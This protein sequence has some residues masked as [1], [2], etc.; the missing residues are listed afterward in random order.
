MGNKGNQNKTR[1]I[2][3][4]WIEIF[5]NM[6]VVK[7]VESTGKC[8]ISADEIKKVYEP[9]LMTKFDYKDSLPSIFVENS[10]TILP[11]TRGSYV[12]GKY[13]AYEDFETVKTNVKKIDFPEWIE[14][15]DYKN[16]YSEASVINCAYASKIFSDILG[17]TEMYP[18]LN[19]RMGSGDF[20][21]YINDV[22]NKSCKVSVSKAQCEID[23]AFESRNNILLLEAKNN[24]FEDFI[25]RQLYYPYRV[26]QNRVSKKVIP[27]FLTYSNNI[28]S[29]Y[30]YEFSDINHY[31]SLKL[32]EVKRYMIDDFNITVE[33]VKD[34]LYNIKIVDE[35]MDIPFPQA[36]TFENIISLINKMYDDPDFNMKDQVT[37]E[38]GF[39]KRQADY[40]TNA[41][42]YLGLVDRQRGKGKVIL[43]ELGKKIIEMRSSEKYLTLFKLILSHKVFNESMRV[44]LK[45]LDLPSR[46]E[47]VQIMKSC[48][49]NHVNTEDMYKRRSQTIK[50]WINWIM[51]IV[52]ISQ[53]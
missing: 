33:D 1:K 51:E 48:N 13:K 22:N 14:G 5:N 3:K 28:F 9:R 47:I 44:F 12:I 39:D 40:Y 10:L 50:K 20:S 27:A 52:S 29:F 34:I 41:V 38:F 6:N 30:I 26:I 16:L 42:A 36:D 53:S 21:F 43:S 25:V 7:E 31:N 35:S 4:Y 15:I 19:G 2:D 8:I 37:I 17:E 45:K 46:A 24:I 32:R 18:T 11:I 49:L 23:G